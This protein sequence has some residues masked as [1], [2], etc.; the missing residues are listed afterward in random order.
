MEDSLTTSPANGRRS[1]ES[2]WVTSRRRINLGKRLLIRAMGKAG[3]TYRE[4]SRA[5]DVSVGAVN[6]IIREEG[7]ECTAL[8]DNIRIRNAD[9]HRVLAE[10][11]LSSITDLDVSR[12]SL[13]HKVIA[14][15]ILTDK[16][17]LLEKAQWERG[18]R[19][20]KARQGGSIEQ[21]N[22]QPAGIYYD[23]YSGNWEEYTL[24][25]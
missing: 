2:Q 8:A 5:L 17:E 20:G 24:R 1:T 7:P 9:R 11:I 13:K 14:A 22:E 12:A 23:K 15:A 3:H 16:A 19:W 4:I 6:Y 18:C 21:R 25:E 10:H